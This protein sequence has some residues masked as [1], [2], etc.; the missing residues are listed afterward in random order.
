[1]YLLLRAPEFEPDSE[2]IHAVERIHE[3]LFVFRSVRRMP[4]GDFEIKKDG[5]H[6]PSL[7]LALEESVRS[8]E[9]L[10]EK[11][12]DL[13]RYS[14]TAEGVTAAGG[15]WGAA[16]PL[17]REEAVETKDQIGGTSYRELVSFL[18]AEFPETWMDPAMKKKAKEWG[19]EAACSM[20]DRAKVS[21]SSAARM[22]GTTY[23]GFMRAYAAAG[24]VTFKTT[25][26]E[27]DG[28]LDELDGPTCQQRGSP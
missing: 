15:P 14:L 17:E 28:D 7:A 19:P 2:R 22:H 27:I 16:D 9:V 6:S 10:H 4:V 8:G 12:G 13:D 24:Y 11:I 5:C 23:E 25:A 1:M 3:S 26:E 18:Y 21:I 20:Y